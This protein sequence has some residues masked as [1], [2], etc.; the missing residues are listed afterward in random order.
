MSV[1]SCGSN[2]SRREQERETPQA[3]R[4]RVW[5][6]GVFGEPAGATGSA[7]C[8]GSSRGPQQPGEQSVLLVIGSGLKDTRSAIQSVG[9]PYVIEPNAVT[10]RDVV[11]RL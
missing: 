6:D 10:R 4:L 11:T 3:I 9:R 2:P 1:R 8:E 5:G 7:A